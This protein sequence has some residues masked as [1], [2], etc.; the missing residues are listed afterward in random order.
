MTYRRLWWASVL[1]VA[2]PSALLALVLAPVAVLM[3]ATTAVGVLGGLALTE[4]Q[5]PWETWGDTAAA[6]VLTAAIVPVLGPRA[7]PLL[8]LWVATSVPALRVVSGSCGAGYPLGRIDVSPGAG[9]PEVEGCLRAMTG[10]ELCRAWLHSF[11]L[12]KSSTSLRERRLQ[13]GVRASLLDEL[14][15]RDGESFAAWLRRSPSPASTPTWVL[16]EP[17]RSVPPA[18]LPRLRDPEGDQ[19]PGATL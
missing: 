5:V 13:A 12:A 6:A 8:L 18:P 19:D 14:E 3:V 2:V 10:E 17:G 4:H 7:A 1:A 11:A 16:T 9:D 15:R